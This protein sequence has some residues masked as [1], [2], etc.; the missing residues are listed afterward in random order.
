[1]N[2]GSCRQG[3]EKAEIVHRCIARSPPQR[4]QRGFPVHHGLSSGTHLDKGS[5]F[6]KLREIP[7][8][9]GNQDDAMKK[10]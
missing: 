10:P 6:R 7:V 2:S 4:G 5:W 1:L 3:R 9:P 8:Q